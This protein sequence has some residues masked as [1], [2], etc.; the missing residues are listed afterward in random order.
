MLLS[1]VVLV[2]AIQ[3]LLVQLWRGLSPWGL[4]EVVNQWACTTMTFGRWQPSVADWVKVNVDGSMSI[5]NLKAFV[6][7]AV[8]GPNGGWLVGFKMVLGM[9]GIFQIEAKA[10]LEGL[11][12]A[13]A[14]GFKCVEL[15]SDNAMLIEIIHNGLATLSSVAEVRQIH[16]WCSKN[17][18]V[19]FRH[20]QWNSNKVANCIAKADGGVIE[21]LVILDDPPQYVRC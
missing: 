19:K 9:N 8:R 17:W 11:K 18:E 14:K 12:L 7:K 5:N 3:N 15:E 21:K 2:G 10:I 20:I 6:G 16:D 13:W 1:L 4:K